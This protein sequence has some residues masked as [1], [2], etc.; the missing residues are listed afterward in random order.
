M[1]GLALALVLLS[2]L[3]Q[4][5]TAVAV[6]RGDQVV[7]QHISGEILVRGWE[8]AE[9]EVVGDDGEAVEVRVTRAGNRLVIGSD[10]RRGRRNADFTLY[11]PRWAPVEIVGLELDVRLEGLDAG[12]SVQ[13]VEGDISVRGTAGSLAVTTVDGEVTVES[14]RGAVRVDAQADDVVVR[15]VIGDVRVTSGTGDIDLIQ[16]DGDHVFA[17]TIDGELTFVGPLHAGGTYEFS[18]HSGDADVTVPPEVS[19]E[20]SVSTFDGDFASDFPVTLRRSSTGQRFS[21]TL[22]GGAASLSIRVFDGEIR[23]RQGRG[24]P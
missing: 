8:R 23:L 7:V 16:I 12:A 22:G 15:D 5:D 10:D 17:E 3:A 24:R 11:V 4:P 18:T 20:V 6:G 1:S 19:A 21:F 14:V 2:G 13:N 9:L